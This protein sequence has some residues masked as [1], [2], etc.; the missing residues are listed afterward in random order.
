MKLFIIPKPVLNN[1]MEVIAY[2]F[3]YKRVNANFFEQPMYAFDDAA[4]PL[5]LSLLNSV[6]LEGFTNGIQT[7]VPI[8]KLSLLTDIENQCS[9]PPEKIIFLLSKDIPTEDV[10]LDSI[11]RLKGLGFRFAFENIKDYSGL[12]SVLELCDFLF[13]S[14]DMNGYNE[15]AANISHK[16]G[17]L[18]LVLTDV[19]DM[20]SFDEV[21]YTKFSLFEGKFFCVPTTKE[22]NTIS[23]IK[24]NSI[25]LINTIRDEDFD[26]GD[27]AKVVGQD[28]SLSIALMKF[29]NSPYLGLNQQIKT[30]QHAVAM[31]G[32]KEVRKWVTTA[33]AEMLA[34]DK[35]DEITKL[36]LMRA[37]LAENLAPSFEMA[38]HAPSLFLMGL[39]SI[40]DAV[41]EMP[42][43]EAL[44]II[45][46]SDEIQK[47]LV[48]LEGK[49]AKV[50]ELIYKYE[51]ADWNDVYRLTVLHN[52]DAADVFS[53]YMDAVN[54]Y[55][56]IASG[57]VEG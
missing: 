40:L 34:S 32:Q 28:P 26:I 36:S 38:I 18:K 16:Y 48:S 10:F 4:S 21:K 52:I 12:D 53:A 7:F 41:L 56:S 8:N 57:N 15:T 1:Q 39:F 3:R 11:K 25:Q 13:L 55:K 33:T 42:M 35:P 31:L 23:P 54:W 49:Y 51:T 9:E 5:C 19:D 43:V 17:N 44:K 14:L 27:I 6:G 24:V 2:C 37:K 47:A 29:V 46:V 50:L 30:I 45:N 20:K 22:Y